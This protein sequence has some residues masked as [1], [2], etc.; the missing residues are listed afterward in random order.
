MTAW[1]VQRCYERRENVIDAYFDLADTVI[2]VR[3]L[4]RQA[5]TTYRWDSRP[6]RRR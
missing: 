4:I 2:T 5:W 6:A 1:S 3:S